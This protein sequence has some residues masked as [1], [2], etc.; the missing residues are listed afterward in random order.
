MS[1][2]QKNQNTDIPFIC[3]KPETAFS[4]FLQNVQTNAET[5]ILTDLAFMR[6]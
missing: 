3:K 1:A 6:V 4:F 5:C 2:T